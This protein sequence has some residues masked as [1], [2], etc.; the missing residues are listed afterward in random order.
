M[1]S[2]DRRFDEAG[3][4]EL[5][6]SESAQ[7]PRLMRS[8]TANASKSISPRPLGAASCF[9]GGMTAPPAGRSAAI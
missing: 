9:P 8:W 3:V 1:A 6:V 7:A 4:T 5:R 2:C